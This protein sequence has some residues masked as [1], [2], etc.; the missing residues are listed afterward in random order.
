MNNI[1]IYIYIIHVCI[2]L[3]SKQLVSSV[4]T[5][6][7]MRQF[8]KNR[9]KPLYK[10]RPVHHILWRSGG[11]QQDLKTD[12]LHHLRQLS[13][14]SQ[15]NQRKQSLNGTGLQFQVLTSS[16]T[17]HEWMHRMHDVHDVWQILAS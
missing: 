13:D 8:C 5:N 14:Q 17:Q 15:A 9:Y 2:Y 3:Y 10:S 12:H 16:K 7:L 11:M 1:C 4:C 6:H